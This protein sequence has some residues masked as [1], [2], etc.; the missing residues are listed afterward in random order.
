MTTNL[1]HKKTKICQINIVF[2]FMYR[3]SVPLS[4]VSFPTF[5]SH[6]HND[7][8]RIVSDFV[9]ILYPINKDW[10][11]ENLVIVSFVVVES[12]ITED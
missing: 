4:L 12:V 8:G 2:L 6:I 5:L 10:V 9:L 11:Q 3:F 1:S 7:S